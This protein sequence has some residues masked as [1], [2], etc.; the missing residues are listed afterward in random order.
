M[1]VSG[2]KFDDSG[3]SEPFKL[4]DGHRYFLHR[5]NREGDKG[6][7]YAMLGMDVMQ[8]ITPYV[9]ESTMDVVL[10][11]RL[12]PDQQTTLAL[13]GTIVC[14]GCGAKV[15]PEG[16]HYPPEP[17]KLVDC[18]DCDG[19]GEKVT[20]GVGSPLGQ[21]PTCKGSGKV[22]EGHPSL[23]EPGPKL[24]PPARPSGGGGGSRFIR[25]G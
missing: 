15:T 1:K 8:P 21:C 20:A 25:R 22:P 14:P 5:I 6:P 23:G 9:G 4:A 17:P 10:A 18:P 24:E 19:T 16:A 12:G 3:T 2:L 7:V 11:K 13:D